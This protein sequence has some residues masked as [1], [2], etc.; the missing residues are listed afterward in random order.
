MPANQGSGSL[1]KAIVFFDSNLPGME[2]CNI[3]C[4]VRKNILCV[5]RF[6]GFPEVVYCNTALFSGLLDVEM[7]I[8]F[9]NY[10]L[11]RLPSFN[12]KDRPVF[13]V[14]THD[15]NFT[16]DAKK[17]WIRQRQ[18]LNS[19]LKLDFYADSISVYLPFMGAYFDLKVKTIKTLKY[20]KSRDKDRQDMI[21]VCNKTISEEV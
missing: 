8:Y 18:E 10:V 9:I 4:E 19:H 12:E 20:G 14:L 17:G 1:T 16:T 3:A 11:C 5:H 6:E 2:D 7:V 21:E 15:V 13:I